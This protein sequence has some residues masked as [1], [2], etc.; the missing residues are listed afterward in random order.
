[1]VAGIHP[2]WDVSAFSFTHQRQC[3]VTSPHATIFLEVEGNPATQRRPQETQGE[4]LKL[5][6]DTSRRS[7]S[8]QGPW[9]YE[10][11]NATLYLDQ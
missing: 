6:T 2:V 8:K 10:V 4:H 11:G 3:K 1:M 5:L 7:G 9:N